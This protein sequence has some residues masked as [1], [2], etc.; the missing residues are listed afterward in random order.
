MYMKARNEDI[1]GQMFQESFG[2]TSGVP[3]GNQQIFLDR[4]SYKRFC[5]PGPIVHGDSKKPNN[6]SY[7][8][9]EVDYGT[10]LNSKYSYTAPSQWS[11]TT[12]SGCIQFYWYGS[13]NPLFG[14]LVASPFDSATYNKA[15]AKLVDKCRGSMDLMV[16][17]LQAGQTAK[18]FNVIQSIKD[19]SSSR[20]WRKLLKASASARLEYEYGW[21]PLA[22]S[23][24]DCITE[25]QNI[26]AADLRTIKVRASTPVP[27]RVSSVSVQYIGAVPVVVERGGRYM[28]EICVTL[29]TRSIDPARWASLNPVSWAWE[30]TPYSFV[31][32][33]MIDVGGY[34]RNLET[35]LLYGNSFVTGYITQLCATGATFSG[36]HSRSE[37]A[38]GTKTTYQANLKGS[39][40]FIAMDRSVL[41]SFPA[42]R[43]PTFEADLGA[44]RLLN[45]AALLAQKLK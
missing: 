1:A 15:Y 21:L 45:L 30:L 5:A 11:S 10:G 2:V 8:V 31:L 19:Y 39:G 9:I 38:W 43:L 36:S 26:I 23:L 22:S 40:R 41:L 20:G 33:W 24:Y 29:K 35:S 12:Q 27:N 17:T 16:D 3:F 34:I 32:D 13:E 6:W 37:D 25:I 44:T 4:P 7:T 28:C 14:D 42:P 18:M